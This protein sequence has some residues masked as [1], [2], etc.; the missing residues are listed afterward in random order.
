MVI[1]SVNFDLKI[2]EF[3]GLMVNIGDPLHPFLANVN[4]C[5]SSLYDIAVLSVCNIGAPLYSAG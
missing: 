5:S 1:A 2:N 4:L 3:P